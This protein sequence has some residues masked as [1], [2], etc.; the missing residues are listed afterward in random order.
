MALAMQVTEEVLS[1]R[2]EADYKLR[3][4]LKRVIAAAEHEAKLAPVKD[5]LLR[6]CNALEIGF[7]GAETKI[8]A[9][10]TPKIRNLCL[11]RELTRAIQASRKKAGLNVCSLA[12]PHAPGNTI[13]CNDNA[14]LASPA[15][16]KKEA[17][18]A[19]DAL[20]V[21]VLQ[22][23][24]GG[25]ASFAATSAVTNR[26]L[27]TYNDLTEAELKHLE[28]LFKVHAVIGTTNFGV[29]YN[30]LSVVANSRGALAGDKCTGFEMQR[31][32]EAFS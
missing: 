19:A 21:E 12:S 30:S 15:I 14:A 7:E 13:L 24:F 4:P 10:M 20:G 27:L 9:E 29:P 26:G 22:Q 25:L 6:A 1:K 17:K 28:K 5:V 18:R 11:Y 31:V 3:W 23:S 32:F 16:P 8:D 2:K